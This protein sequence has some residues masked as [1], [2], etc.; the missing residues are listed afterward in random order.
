MNKTINKIDDIFIDEFY[1]IDIDPFWNT[2]EQKELKVHR[3]HAY[4]AKFPAFIFEKGIEYAEQEHYH[5][6]IVADIFCGCGT[7]ALEAKRKNID[8]W[9]CDINPVATMIAKTKSNNYNTT[10][11]TEIFNSILDSFASIKYIKSPYSNAPE[12]LQYWYFEREYNDLYRLKEAIEAVTPARSSYRLFFYCAFSNILKPTSRWLTKSIKPQL[13]PDKSPANVIMVFSEQC[14]N[15]INAFEELNLSSA[16]TTKIVTGSFLDKKIKRPHV[17]MILTS[18]PYVTSYEYA[19]LHQ[20]SS[21]WLNYTDDYRKLRSGSIGSLYRNH[22][23]EIKNTNLSQ[24]GQRV[25]SKL[26]EKDKRKARSVAKYFFDM[27]DVI[28]ECAKMIN[29]NGFLMMVVGDTKYKGVHIENARHVTE[30]MFFNGFKAISVS[31]RKVTGK[32]LTPYR[33]YRGRFTT[34]PS[35]RRIYGE[36]F[37]IIGRKE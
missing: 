30:L 28:K 22:N 17:D 19:D 10:R 3:I 27:Q 24:T 25:V 2:G 33:D 11:I 34:N 23:F 7:V 29:K 6:K 4:P 16:S 18:P 21:L 26:Y 14:R 37:I 20:L 12:R 15:M 31:K 35:S 32:I 13:D 9:G 5:P 36:E 1:D 8:F